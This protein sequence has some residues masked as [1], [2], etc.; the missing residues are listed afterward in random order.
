MNQ[1]DQEWIREEIRAEIHSA[2]NPVGWDKLSYVIRKWGKPALIVTLIAALCTAVI[3]LGIRVVDNVEKNAE[4]RGRTEQRLNNIEASLLE[5]RGKLTAAS[6]QT[7]IALPQ[8]AFQNGLS[9]LKSNLAEARSLNVKVPIPLLEDLE[10]KLQ[11][12][13]QN[14]PEF[15][16]TASEFISYRSVV[17]SPSMNL[18]KLTLEGF[19]DCVSN[20]PTEAKIF[21]VLPEN[22]LQQTVQT[23]EPTYEN[24]RITLDS[25]RDEKA[26]NTYMLTT[27]PFIAFKHCLVVYNG[28]AVNI[29]FYIP[30]EGGTEIMTNSGLVTLTPTKLTGA[31]LEF[32]DCLFEFSI[33]KVPPKTG[34]KMT[35][36][37]LAQNN[38][39]VKFSSP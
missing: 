15:W 27:F 12:S 19:S 14:A 22:G 2:L 6:I 16:P 34:L 30:M 18:S 9:A 4:F 7:Q 11:N 10:A 23:N 26:L 32:F 3:M 24:C 17:L 36:S 29:I 28:G 20:P 39:P 13:D 35:E 38:N 25:P 21:K 8:S 5:I 31:S 1:R 33:P 37:L